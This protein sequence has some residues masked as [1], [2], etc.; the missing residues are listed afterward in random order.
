MPDV[1]EFYEMVTGQ[2]PPVMA[3]LDR[4]QK[5][6]A[7]AA[8]HRRIGAFAVAIAIGVVAVAVILSSRVVEEG[9]TPAND[10]EAPANRDEMPAVVYGTPAE[11]LGR[12]FLEAY[13]D[14]DADAAITYLAP[15]ADIRGF[16]GSLGTQGVTGSTDDLRRYLALLEAMRY[17]QNG[18]MSCEEVGTSASGT[19]LRCPFWFS[20]LGS[21]EFGRGA[22][23][24]GSTIRLMVRDGAIVEASASWDLDRFTPDSWE[25][26]A[27]W[28]SGTHPDAVAVMYEDGTRAPRLT[29]ESIALWRQLLDEYVDEVGTIRN[30]PPGEHPMSVDGI[31]FSLEVPS[32]GWAQFGTIS[33]N[34]SITGPQGAEAMVFWTRFPEGNGATWCGPQA[35]ASATMSDLASVIAAAPGTELVGGPTDVTVGGYPAKHVVVRVGQDLGCDPG[36]FFT[37]R[38]IRWGPLWPETGVGDTIRVWIV[39]V[40][41]TLVFLEAETNPQ[42]NASLERQIE[43]MVSS[44]R[45]DTP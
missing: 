25:P 28:V 42:A 40:G 35:P 26:F 30:A 8:R 4:Q 20:L 12:G 19:E 23:F 5:L 33:L 15:D 29:E 7:R 3:A 44:I 43:Q 10:G 11:R 38:D 37:W 24:T 17:D 39:D 16:V 27:T 45:F 14:F 32:H 13:R 31:P 1:R 21:Y 2:T 18:I 36:Y 9:T 22:P 41:G 34:M 6:Q